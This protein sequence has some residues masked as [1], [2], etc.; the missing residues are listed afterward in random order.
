MKVIGVIHADFDRGPLGTAARL[1]DDLAGRS[2]LRRTLQQ[3]LRACPKTRAGPASSRSISRVLGQAPNANHLASVHLVVQAA[4]ESRARAAV[5]GLDVKIETHDAA[6][7]PWRDYL[8]TTRKW[9]MDAWRGGIGGTC[10]FDES[11]HPWVLDALARRE[12]ADG[13]VDIPAAAP[14]LDPVLLTAMIEHF[15]KVADDV[16]MTFTQSAPGLTAAIYAPSLLADLARTSQCPG[17]MM[18]YNP[19]EPRRDMIMLPC[20]CAPETEVRRARGR[21]MV[22]TQDAMQRVAACLT[23]LGAANNDPPDAAAVSRWLLGRQWTFVPDLPAEVEIELTTEDSLPETT[24]RPRG[25]IVGRRGPMDAAVFERLIDELAR[26]D[27]VR[28]VLGGFGDPLLHP[29][30]SRLARRCRETGIF[31]LAVRTPAV[32]LDEPAIENLLDTKVDVLNV[33]I[34]AA[35]AET[36]RKL[37]RADRFDRVQSNIEKLI[38]AQQARRQSQPLVVC[39]MIK[40]RETMN[41]IEPFYDRWT[42]RTGAAVIVGP[43]DYAGQ[44]SD[45]AVMNMAPPTRFACGRLFDRTMVLADGRVTACDQDFKGQHAIG[46]LTDQSLGDL[47]K[48]DRMNAIRR[49]HQTATCDAMPLCRSCREWHRP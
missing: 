24:L 11:L 3:V 31:G 47:W 43:S 23:E 8:I 45:L 42:S 4:Q 29:E 27:D 12:Q 14:L 37:H 9:S 13:V 41:E 6:A 35:T 15:G 20:F 16:R 1:T 36:Y 38:E 33:P 30:F 26:R 46:S 10:V 39:E 19:A 2:V 28:I 17:R 48:C 21:C 44:F 18:A 22:D 7:V 32:T 34:D 25:P 40:T 5:D 49:S